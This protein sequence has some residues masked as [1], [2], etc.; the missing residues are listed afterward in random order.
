MVQN[1]LTFARHHKPEREYSNINDI[2]QKA[3]ELRSY[4]LKTSNIEL[5]TDLAP[6]LPPVKVDSHQIQEVF[7]NIIINAEQAMAEANRG[8]KLCVKTDERKGHITIIFSDDGPGI[9][10][11]NLNKLFDP[12]FTTRAEKGGTGLGLSI[13]HG[14][15]TEHGGKIYA[16]SKPGTGVTFFVELPVITAELSESKIV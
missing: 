8:G 4:E 6:N 14:I 9:P 2:V 1:L 13:C 7:L 3:L 12:F 11:E 5:V 15:V 10:T 16:K